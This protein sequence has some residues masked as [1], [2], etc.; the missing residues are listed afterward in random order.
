MSSFLPR[1]D[2][3]H[4]QSEIASSRATKAGYV[5]TTQARKDA[6]DF[7]IQQL[8][9]IRAIVPPELEKE[10]VQDD[11]EEGSTQPGSLDVSRAQS[12]VPASAVAGEVDDEEEGGRKEGAEEEEEEETEGSRRKGDEVE[13]EAGRKKPKALV[14]D[15]AQN[16]AEETESEPEVDVDLQDEDEAAVLGALEGHDEQPPTPL[17]ALHPPQQASNAIIASESFTISSSP[18]S[19]LPAS[20]QPPLSAIPEA[21]TSEPAPSSPTALYS[22]KPHPTTHNTDLSPSTSTRSSSMPPTRRSSRTTTSPIATTFSHSHDDLVGL[23][24]SQKRALESSLASAPSSP[25]SITSESM[26]GPPKARNKRGTSTRSSLGAGNES[27]TST[28]Y[29]ADEESRADSSMI[30]DDAEEAPPLKK[31]K[32]EPETAGRDSD[33]DLSDAPEE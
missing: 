1:S 20:P 6:L 16:K 31:A 10:E 24:R 19:S 23:T 33:S 17:V 18:T 4:L 2:I 8:E 12:V 32:V 26:S 7:L 29:R 14:L 3:A 30:V 22:V 5:S 9:A 28:A 25:P 21:P 13:A 27:S 11:A 15:P